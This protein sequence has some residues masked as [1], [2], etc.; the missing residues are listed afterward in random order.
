MFNE[1]SG[2]LSSLLGGVI[3]AFIG[4]GIAKL[5]SKKPEHP[6][7]PQRD[8]RIDARIN[9]FTNY[10]LTIGVGVFLLNGVIL[11]YIGDDT[12]RLVFLFQFL[13]VGI[14]SYLIGVDVVGKR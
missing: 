10:F 11:E 6:N 5:L 7:L 3:G 14:F 13:L 1:G 4:L 12:I 2:V 9:K 8:E